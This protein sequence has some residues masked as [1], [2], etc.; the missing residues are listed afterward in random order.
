MA[1]P[2]SESNSGINSLRLLLFMV[3]ILGMLTLLVG[4]STDYWSQGKKNTAVHHGLWKRCG[5]VGVSD[6]SAI[7]CINPPTMTVDG[8]KISYVLFSA[9]ATQ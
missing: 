2:E 9:K 8:R 3:I 4:I 6:K 1:L 7:K 5:P